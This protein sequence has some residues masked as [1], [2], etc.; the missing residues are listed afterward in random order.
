MP[1]LLYARK[2]LKRAE[3]EGAATG[4][5]P[6]GPGADAAARDA[7]EREVGEAL[8]EAVRSSRRLGVDPE[9]AL[10]RVAQ[11]RLGE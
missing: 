10:R 4:G 2:L 1:A 5:K 7:A 3:P 11:E 6:G 8:L 9:L